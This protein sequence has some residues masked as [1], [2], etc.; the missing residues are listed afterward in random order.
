MERQLLN[1]TNISLNDIFIKPADVIRFSSKPSLRGSGPVVVSGAVRQPGTYQIRSGERVS[2]LLQRAGGLTDLAYPY[3]AVFLRESIAKAEK[4]ALIRLT[5]ELNTALVAAATNRRVDADSIAALSGLARTLNTAPATGRMVI[6]ADPT[7]LISKPELDVI[8]EP[9]D[10]LFIPR[11]P[12][13][14]LVT[15]DVLNPGAMQFFPGK[16]VGEYVNSAGGY[17]RSADRNKVFVVLPNG[18]AQ[19]A[20]NF[21]FQYAEAQVPPGSTVVVPKDATP[22][23]AFNLTREVS[24]VFS[25]LAVAAAALKVI[26]GN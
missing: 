21:F 22:F 13:S 15:G 4:D 10:L 11:R 18:S 7:V 17:Q 8:L 19:P 2:E 26:A 24:Q 3:G 6:E 20:G 1:L 16:S 14:V 23:D 9:G 5:R 12:S 25:Q